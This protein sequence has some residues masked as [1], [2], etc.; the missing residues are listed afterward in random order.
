MTGLNE[1]LS[2][3]P[4]L[5]LVLAGQLHPEGDSQRLQRDMLVQQLRKAGLTQAE[6]EGRTPAWEKA[7]AKRQRALHSESPGDQRTS[8]EKSRPVAAA[9]DSPPASLEQLA[10]Q[11]AEPVRAVLVD[12]AGL[13]ADRV[14]VDPGRINTDIPPISGVQLFLDN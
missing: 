5:S 2:Q 4:A 12:E 3:R 14:T 7:V 1:A 8:R 9:M 11:R 13:A 6:I 10:A